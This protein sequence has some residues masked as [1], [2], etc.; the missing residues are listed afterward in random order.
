VARLAARPK[1]RPA[2]AN[3]RDANADEIDEALKKP[4]K[5]P[6]PPKPQPQPKKPDPNLEAK[7]ESKLALLDKR[8]SERQTIANSMVSPASIG[9]P[10]ANSQ[11]LMQSWMGALRARVESF[12]DIPAGARYVAA[13]D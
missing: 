11:F 9:A 2:Q 8:E 13:L 6:P 3:N 4:D 5:K 12:W 10:N 1:P 7:I